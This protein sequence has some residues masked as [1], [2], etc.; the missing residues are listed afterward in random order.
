MNRSI[1]T[2]GEIDIHEFTI[3]SHEFT[4]NHE[5]NIRI[6]VNIFRNILFNIILIIRQKIQ[7]K[8]QNLKV[9]NRAFVNLWLSHFICAAMKSFCLRVF[10]AKKEIR[11]FVVITFH[12]RFNIFEF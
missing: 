5:H 3:D 7:F 11:E 9:K 12:L 8:N 10:V 2:Y 6:G 4:N 1:G